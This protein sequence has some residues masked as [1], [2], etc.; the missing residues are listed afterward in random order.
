[1]WRL[2]FPFTCSEIF[3][4]FYK[5]FFGKVKNG[6]KKCP[7]FKNGNKSSN[8]KNVETIKKISVSSEKKVLKIVT[9]NFFKNNFILILKKNIGFSHFLY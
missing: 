2:K 1:M 4:F 7:N 8:L 6:Q 5:D 3:I 9:I